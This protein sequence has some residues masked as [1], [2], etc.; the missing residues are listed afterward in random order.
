MSHVDAIQQPED[1]VSSD[2]LVTG[3]YRVVST[4]GQGGMGRVLLA[5]DQQ[6]GR[7][8]ALKQIQ[9]A[10]GIPEAERAQML[11]RVRREARIAANLDHPAIV[12]VHDIVEHQN[13]P[14]IVMEYLNG[15]SLGAVIRDDGPVHPA[16]V[17][18]IAAS[19]LQALGHAHAAGVVHRDLKPDNIVLTRDGRTVLTDFGIARMADGGTALTTPG[20][21]P[22]TPAFMSPE[23]IEGREVTGAADLW[24]LGATLHTAL[25]GRQPFD[26]NTMTEL[27]IAILTRPAP[28]SLHAGELG[29][30]LGGLL[31]KDVTQRATVPQALQF[32]AELQSRAPYSA[33]LS[34]I[35]DRVESG[36]YAG[37]GPGFTARVS[38]PRNE[39][40]YQ[41]PAIAVAASAAAWIAALFLRVVHFGHGADGYSGVD[42]LTGRLDSPYVALVW[43]LTVLTLILSA[44]AAATLLPPFARHAAHVC[45]AAIPV[46]LVIAGG[47]LALGIVALGQYQSFC[48]NGDPGSFEFP[49]L[50]G[51]SNACY[52][53]AGLDLGFYF[54]VATA[55]VVVGSG[56]WALIIRARA[57]RVA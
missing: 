18:R 27:C 2:H 53:Q 39:S 47:E 10:S 31:A 24:S 11:D 54:G 45:W 17:A 35:A 14:V 43:A 40:P 13:S 19:V 26:G 42:V 1:L 16:H 23:Q 12:R 44:L 56:I 8:V 37:Y 9:L 36:P 5:E 49:S 46:G 29:P 4:I 52:N 55:A 57:P 20:A 33:P 32:L 34:T 7:Q 15:R 28:S 50:F 48:D 30:L 25:E 3:R 41:A 21:I 22:G 51:S 38:A 6:L